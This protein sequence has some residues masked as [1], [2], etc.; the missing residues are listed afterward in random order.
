V[1]GALVTAAPR[2]PLA[3]LVAGLWLFEGA[4]APHARDRML[5]RGAAE[6]V[7]DLRPEDPGAIASGLATRPWELPTAAQSAALGVVLRPGGVAA[8]LGLPAAELRDERVRLDA[9]WGAPAAEALWAPVLAARGPRARLA[10][11][12]ALLAARLPRAAHAP[13]PAARAA[14]ARI[15]AAP[16]RLRVGALAADLGLSARR[17]EQVL[18]LD[19]GL[20]PKPLARL[21]RFRRALERLEDADRI[22]W[23]AFAAERGFA[24]Q[25]HLI[26][27]VRAFAGMTPVELR[28]ARGPHLNHVPLAA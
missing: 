4:P 27:E 17:L 1:S 22:G 12:E 28:A 15:A 9:L 10:A 23:A 13:H 16:E 5:P 2:G 11:A 8:L 14:V 6:L 26:A 24:D 3:A 7:L 19:V 18:R 21:L 25:S 20:A